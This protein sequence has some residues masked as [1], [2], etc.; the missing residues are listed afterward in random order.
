MHVRPAAPNHYYTTGPH[1]GVSQ[2]QKINPS[3]AESPELSEVLSW[4]P[5][6]CKIT[7]LHV[8]LTDTNPA[9]LI[10]VFLV[11]SFLFVFPSSSNVK[12]PV[13]PT[14]C[15]TF[16]LM[17]SVSL[18]TRRTEGEVGRQDQ[19]MDRPGVS[20]VPEGSGELRKLEE[21]GY[22]VICGAQT[23]LAVKG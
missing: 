3:S 15:Q 19:G 9:F 13:S 2:T 14:V 20:Q 8:Q 10:S 5:R 18:K 12:W 23:T 4:K 22:E 11:H 17:R 1:S 16:D 21:T 7:A 6:A